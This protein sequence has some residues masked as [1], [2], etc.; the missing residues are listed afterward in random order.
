MDLLL[1]AEYGTV[2][3]SE[4]EVAGLGFDSIGASSFR[5]T[6]QCLLACP[7]NFDMQ[8]HSLALDLYEDSTTVLGDAEFAPSSFELALLKIILARVIVI[9]GTAL[10][11]SFR[12]VYQ[13]A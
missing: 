7:K 1:V 8:C 11:Q 3:A 2:T 10:E 13:M 9:T 4:T 12:R 5:D 6:L